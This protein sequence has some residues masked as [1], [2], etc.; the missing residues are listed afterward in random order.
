MSSSS[1]NSLFRG[2]ISVRISS[3]FGSRGLE[4]GLFTL[5]ERCFSLSIVI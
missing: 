2:L 5:L 3:R 1:I 4:V